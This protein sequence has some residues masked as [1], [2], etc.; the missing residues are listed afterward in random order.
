[1][2]IRSIKFSG[3]WQQDPL[4][5]DGAAAPEA[6][7]GRGGGR[8]GAGAG[9]R[10][11]DCCICCN[12][13]TQPVQQRYHLVTVP[14]SNWQVGM[15]GWQSCRSVCGRKYSAV[16]TCRTSQQ[17]CIAP[18][19]WPSARTLGRRPAAAWPC[20]PPRRRRRRRCQFCRRCRVW[21]RL[22][23][24]M[25]SDHLQHV[26]TSGGIRSVSNSGGDHV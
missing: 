2:L 9:G 24:R 3:W 18:A 20:L 23:A 16:R 12:N 1:M 4:P 21:S 7:G 26:L 5:V 15:L 10:G 13:T 14:K 19:S 11:P 22:S 17:L 8:G 6:G 25:L